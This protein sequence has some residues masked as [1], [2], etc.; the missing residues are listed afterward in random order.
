M[1]ELVFGAAAIDAAKIIDG[2][3]ITNHWVEPVDGEKLYRTR[4]NPAICLRSWRQGELEERLAIHFYMALVEAA[5]RKLRGPEMILWLDRLEL[6]QDNLRTTM[7][8]ALETNPIKALHLVASLCY[9]WS[10]RASATDGLVWIKAALE[11]AETSLD[12]QIQT[13]PAIHCSGSRLS[14]KSRAGI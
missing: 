8:W 13:E 4:D 10:R 2:S 5:E 7:E 3:L 9:F 14:A 1:Q 11:R 12:T 6:E